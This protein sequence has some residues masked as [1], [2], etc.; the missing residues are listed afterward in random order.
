MEF[1]DQTRALEEKR[2][3]ILVQL[4]PS[5]QFDSEVANE[6]FGIV[7]VAYGGS[8]VCEPRHPSWFSTDANAVL[9]AHRI[10]R[11]VADPSPVRESMNQPPRKAGTAYF[12]LH[13][14][15]RMYW[16]RYTPDYLLA[17]ARTV[18]TST[19][20]EV[21]CVFDNTASGAAIENALELQELLGE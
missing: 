17:L 21:W 13:G 20:A 16:S 10:P 15:P 12:R 11:V 7:R 5:Q 18:Q 14:S 19:A 8:V 2:G 9:D 3:P 4:P 6:F 1:L